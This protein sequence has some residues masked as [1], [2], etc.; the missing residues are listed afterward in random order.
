MI[1]K[2]FA[3]L[4]HF[5]YDFWYLYF[6]FLSIYC[7]FFWSI[8]M[9]SLDLQVAFDALWGGCYILGILTFFLFWKWFRINHTLKKL[10]SEK[11]ID[12]LPVIQSLTDNERIYQIIIKRNQAVRKRLQVQLNK[13]MQDMQDYYAMWAHQIKVPISVLDLMNQTDTVDKYE[14]SNQLIIINQY[15]DMML[16]FIR[17]KSFNQDLQYQKISVK[18]LLKFVINNYKFLFIHKKISVSLSDEDFSIVSDPKWLQ[19]VF[20]QVIFNALK[21]TSQGKVSITCKNN[22]Q[23]VI[24]DSGIGISQSDLPMVFNKG[25]TGFNGRLN[26]NASGLG[27]YM[28]KSIL[29]QL[30]HGISIS[31]EVNVGTSVVINLKQKKLK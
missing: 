10:I 15:L 18:G 24:A 8:F 14:T 31:S 23:V 27:L 20:E 21:Y 30:G 26:N 4:I 25:Y 9:R 16:Q 28:V 19:F 6:I 7:L 12:D 1:K 17:L 29:N 5:L 3:L 13:N 2:I 11:A 22:N